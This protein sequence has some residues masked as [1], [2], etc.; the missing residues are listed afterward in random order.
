ML[1]PLTL[2]VLFPGASALA[3]IVRLKNGNVLEGRVRVIDGG[4]SYE[5]TSEEGSTVTVPAANVVEHI[6]KEAPIDA[7]RRRLERLDD[8]GIESDELDDLVELAAWAEGKGLR[9]TARAAYR[10]ILRI[11]P[12]Q[13]MAR[14]RLGYVLYR[15][16]WALRRELEQQGLVRSRGIWMTPEEAARRREQVAIDEFRAL[17]ADVHDENPYLRDLAMRRLFEYEDERLLRYL[18]E[19]IGGEDPL[20]RMIAA[21][22]LGNL[23]FERAARRIYTALLVESRNEARQAM[24]VVLRRYGDGRVAGWF[25]R[26]LR[27]TAADH[28]GDVVTRATRLHALMELARY[29]PHR[30]A[31]PGV[32][33][34]LDEPGWSGIAQR[35]LTRVFESSDRSPD[36]WRAWWR[37]HG[38][39][40]SADLGSGWIAD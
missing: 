11:D 34:L 25:G 13:T 6:R 24:V 18:G 9:R 2:L 31:V 32:L 5:V 36:Q 14:D 1:L 21:R 7:F 22:V 19:L 4:A 26:D 10:R 8:G 28:D 12:H 37:E 17:L 33:M 39:A 40:M 29:C 3:D 38:P 15:N 27:Q 16:R 35:W 20:D 30:A 23:P